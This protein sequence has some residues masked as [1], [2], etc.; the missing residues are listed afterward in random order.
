MGS[1]V[2]ESQIVNSKDSR[3]FTG[4]VIENVK[5]GPS[6][7][8]LQ[9]LLRSIG[10]KPINCIVDAGNFIE[11]HIGQ[12]LHAYDRDKLERTGNKWILKA[13]RSSKD[14]AFQALDNKEYKI[15][16]ETLLIKDGNGSTLGIA[17]IKGGKASGIDEN[18]KHIIIEAANFDPVLIRKTSQKLKLRTSASEKFEKEITPELTVL[19]LQEM[20]NM[21][22]E[23]ASD[24]ATRIEGIFDL[25]PNKQSTP[26]IKL[27]KND[28]LKRLG[29]NINQEEIK[30]ILVDLGCE[31]LEQ[32]NLYVVTPPVE[33]LDLNI[34]D[35]LVEEIGRV[36]G[37]EKI[38]ATP[39]EVSGLKLETNINFYTTELVRE[40]LIS[41]GYSEIYTSVFSDKGEREIANKIGGEK[42]FLRSNLLD[43]LKE[44][45]E[46][47]IPNKELID[48]KK[49]KL[50]EIGTIW[51]KDNEEIHIATTGEG[52]EPIEKLLSDYYP[53]ESPDSYPVIETSKT[54]SYKPF[55][56]QPFITRDLSVFVP[57][58]THPHEVEKVFED[59]LTELCVRK[60]LFDQFIKTM[61]DG[62]KKQSYAWRF[63]FQS[64]EKT[65][66]DE[67]V[68]S[69]MEKVYAVLKDRGLEIR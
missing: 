69:I 60:S 1:S 56:R 43:G 33:R 10:Q 68:N 2:F 58:E 23:I 4:L 55:S 50:F 21:L 26:H 16:S 27:G 3:R 28:V 64:Y 8:W 40:D 62:S 18:T 6:P 59:K 7:D 54:L 46:R 42:P 63:V 66:T 29:V 13:E 45:L 37:Y 12:P 5:V 9:S 17:G 34:A 35:D 57:E 39:L 52:E 32:Q 30:K 36:F 61:P 22:L 41:K 15:F 19:A 44:A 25:Y 65:L 49:I 14:E 53:K 67:E 24:R 20:A 48:I 51:K 38:P 47:N 11:Y 31:V